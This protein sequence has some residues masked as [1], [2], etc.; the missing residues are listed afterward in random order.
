MG[1]FSAVTVCDFHGSRCCC[2]GGEYA[3]HRYRGFTESY[4]MGPL[5]VYDNDFEIGK[6]G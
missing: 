1:Q 3:D 2:D 5:S 4:L 6:R